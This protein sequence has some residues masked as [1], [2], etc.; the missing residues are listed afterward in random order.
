[1]DPQIDPYRSRV[2]EVI[3]RGRALRAALAD[4][5]AVRSAS[6]VRIWQHDCEAAVNLLSGGSKAHWLSRAYSEAL[7]VRAPDGGALARVDLTVIVDRLLAV[8]ERAAEALKGA[9]IA[10][11]SSIE[12]FPLPDARASQRFDF[13]HNPDLRPVLEQAYAESRRALDERRFEEALMASC[14]I[15]EAIVTDALVHRDPRAK[16]AIVGWPFDVRLAAAHE[17]GLI[18]NGYA[19]LPAVARAYREESDAIVLEGEAR[20]TAQ[21]LRIVMRDLDPG[22]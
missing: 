21:V 12:S 22:R 13:V 16:D 9:S 7:L 2:D 19:R 11:E 18:R 5:P 4:L 8:L 17:A 10:R 6:D 15:L 20:T 1:V 14:G 3:R